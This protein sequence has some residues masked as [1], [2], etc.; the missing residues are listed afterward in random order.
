MISIIIP[1][2]NQVGLLKQTLSSLVPEK[3]GQEILVVDR[4]SM[5]GAV[6]LARGMPWVRLIRSEAGRNQSLN[7]GVLKAKGGILLFLEPGVRLERGWPVRVEEAAAKPG[8]KVG[9]FRMSIAGQNPMYR[10]IEWTS[11]MRTFL[12]KAARGSQALFVRADL[13]GGQPLFSEDATHADFELCKRY[14]EE[15]AVTQLRRSALQP[16]DRWSRAGVC[17]RFCSDVSSFW[18]WQ[19]GGSTP[20]N[21]HQPGP[22]RIAVMML[23]NRPEARPAGAWLDHAVGADRSAQIYRENV[24][25]ILNSIN[26]SYGET[27]TLVF[28]QP[29][30]AREEMVQWLGDR[31]TLIPQHG[32]T[33]KAA[34]L[35]DAGSHFDREYRKVIVLWSQCPALSK[36]ELKR[37]VDALDDNEIVIGPTDDGGCY[38]IGVK[39][40]DPEFFQ[41]IDW[42]R[43]D[44]YKEMLRRAKAQ[45]V[46]FESLPP[47][48]DFDSIEDFSY[49]YALGY[50]Q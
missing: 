42:S 9:C 8:F 17:R 24:E 6:E 12:F 10:L 25:H 14:A 3:E 48:R 2:K 13:A 45:G 41:D 23:L 15:G 29:K 11:S 22:G 46:A 5:D 26:G 7:E 31:A 49:N 27:D 21:G 33:R 4:G 44:M 1:V 50:V 37:A 43:P 40:F 47:L 38:L 32:R 35:A 19:Q 36:S 39:T 16:A 34:R 20:L 30:S 18:S 28:Y